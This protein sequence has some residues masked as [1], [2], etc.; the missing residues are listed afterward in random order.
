M[1]EWEKHG[2]RVRVRLLTSATQPSMLGATA[3]SRLV[4]LDSVVLAR[5]DAS[6]QAE[7]KVRGIAG[8]VVAT[9]AS[10]RTTLTLLDSSSR[11]TGHS[12]NARPGRSALRHLR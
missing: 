12:Q 6:Y 4:Q 5:K 7:A 10:R 8:S 2:A 1:D 9:A 3:L 11:V